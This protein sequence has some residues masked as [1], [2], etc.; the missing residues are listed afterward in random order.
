[1]SRSDLNAIPRIVHTCE[2]GGDAYVTA[3]QA[4]EEINHLMGA[5][6]PQQYVGRLGS[7]LVVPPSLLARLLRASR[8][9][10]VEVGRLVFVGHPSIKDQVNDLADAARKLG[11]LC[12]AGSAL[13]AKIEAGI[14]LQQERR[15][16]IA[17][18]ADE[19]AGGNVDEAQHKLAAI[20]AAWEE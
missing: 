13:R 15:H 10:H 7:D 8:G 9:E 17:V 4:M 2:L 3:S 5:T 1:M 18:V 20:L 16:Q 12:R 6:K 19:L 11:D 14:E